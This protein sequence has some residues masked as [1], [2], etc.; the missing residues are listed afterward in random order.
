MP[1]SNGPVG[2]VS[3][4]LP[5]RCS[6]KQTHKALHTDH[7]DQKYAYMYT[8]KHTNACIYT[9]THKHIHTGKDLH[10]HPRAPQ[11]NHKRTTHTYN[12]VQLAHKT[13]SAPLPTHTSIH[14]WLNVHHNRRVPVTAHTRISKWSNFSTERVPVTTFSVIIASHFV[15]ISN[16]TIT[17]EEFVTFSTCGSAVTWAQCDLVST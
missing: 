14:I 3:F 9:H 17:G 15:G 4:A 1:N 7:Y 10:K 2:S 13:I 16:V 8:Y 6:V 12:S 11:S 5:F